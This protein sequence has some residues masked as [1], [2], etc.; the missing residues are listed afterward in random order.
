MCGRRAYCGP[1]S[2]LIEVRGHMQ[3]YGVEAYSALMAPNHGRIP[4]AGYL[5]GQGELLEVKL[6]YQIDGEVTSPFHHRVFTV[7]ELAD[8][9]ELAHHEHH[10][11]DPR[12][13]DPREG[14]TRLRLR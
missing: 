1:V 14:P 11:F 13:L 6:S 12:G 3:F 9:W 2:R 5:S 8:A 7:Q 10:G 4:I